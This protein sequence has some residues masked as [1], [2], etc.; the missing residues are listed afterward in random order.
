MSS[1]RAKAR[2]TFSPTW[3]GD[4]S[5][6][7]DAASCE[8]VADA[9]E[10]LEA[11]GA[12]PPGWFS[13][14]SRAFAPAGARV[15]DAYLRDEERDPSRL[16]LTASGEEP[17]VGMLVG[18]M[19]GAV[20]AM[21]SAARRPSAPVGSVLGRVI[22][23]AAAG[24]MTSIDGEV[25]HVM[26]AADMPAAIRPSAEPATPL[27]VATLAALGHDALT[28]AERLAAEAAEGVCSFSPSRVVWHVSV[29]ASKL[30]PW[31]GFGWYAA[32]TDGRAAV[33]PMAG[34]VSA[35][36]FAGRFAA[37]ASAAARSGA[38][39][40]VSRGVRALAALWAMGLA[41]ESMSAAR[42]VV[43]V[44]APAWVR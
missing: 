29:S 17:G 5:A 16:N 44:V 41:L 18:A 35:G 12:V 27:A 28:L 15:G 10:L 9:C 6:A 38:S 25:N 11:R 39:D 22:M 36:Q 33:G 4:L 3:S 8:S 26:R 21:T 34:C 7:E 24:A 14:P 19:F 23:G 42:G 37:M 2:P 32:P 20:V 1:S 30:S 13:S 31:R 43:V 40:G